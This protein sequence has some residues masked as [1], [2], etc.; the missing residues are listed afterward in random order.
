MYLGMYLGMYLDVYDTVR[1]GPYST[2]KTA[3]IPT[4]SSAQLIF[5]S[6][7]THSEIRLLFL[8]KYDKLN[9]V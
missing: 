4:T 6:S 5:P 8:V 9:E 7:P 3:I 2:S 1:Y